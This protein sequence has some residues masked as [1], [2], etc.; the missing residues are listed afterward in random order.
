[1]GHNILP[2][3][4]GDVTGNKDPPLANE[5]FLWTYT[6]PEFPMAQENNLQNFKLPKPVLCVGG[7]MQIELLG[8]VQRQEMD[9][10]FY[11]CVAY[12]QIMGHS[13]SP[14][15]G[16]ESIEPS[17]RFSLLYN[18]QAELSSPSTTH[19]EGEEITVTTDMVQ[20]HV[21]GWE[22]ILNILRGAVGVEVYDSEDEQ[23]ES[24]EEMAEE[25][26]L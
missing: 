3:G 18:P 14:V 7:I 8:R 15:F 12:V 25:F 22:Q 13:L 24:D 2:D 16:I 6:S 19:E 21:R 5:K 23:H 26:A 1:M 10:L 17:G 4:E 9:D 20:T 11:I